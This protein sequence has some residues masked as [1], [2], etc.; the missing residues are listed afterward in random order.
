MKR[1]IRRRSIGGDQKSSRQNGDLKREGR[2]RTGHA[3][4]RNAAVV[5]YFNHGRSYLPEEQEYRAGVQ[6]TP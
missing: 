6:Q 3:H 1:Y 5:G 2:E 4:Y